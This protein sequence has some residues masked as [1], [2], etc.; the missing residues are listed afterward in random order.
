MNVRDLHDMPHDAEPPGAD[1]LAGEY[2]LGVLDAAQRAEVEQRIARDPGFARLVSQWENR[3][4]PLLDSLGTEAVPAHLWPRIRTSLGWP[5]VGATPRAWQR[6]GFWQ[7]MTALAA[8][9][10]LVAVL[11]RRDVVPVAPVAPPVAVTPTT[12]AEPEQATRPVTP[13]LHDDGSPGWLASV[14]KAHGKVLMVPVP[15]P[16]DAAGRAPELWL[17]PAG[18]APRSL[19]LVSINRAHTVAVPD[20]LRDALVNGSVLAITLEPSGGAPQGIP[21]GPV[22]AKGD[23]ANL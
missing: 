15:A 14:D 5:S 21:T 12:P 1:I 9:V 11:A 6:T 23:I 8:V 3:L 13:L 22:I 18:G 7:G 10:A 2:V 17:I 16:A 20:M 4:A 19:G